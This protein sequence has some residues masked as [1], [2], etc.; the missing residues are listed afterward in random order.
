M[1]LELDTIA[2][3]LAVI[4][5][6][7]LQFPQAKENGMG[8]LFPVCREQQGEGMEHCGD[9]SKNGGPHKLIELNA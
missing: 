8:S 4:H 3:I 9:L 7:E 1:T 2:L 5:L 6:L